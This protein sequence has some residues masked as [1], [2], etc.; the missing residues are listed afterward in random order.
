MSEPSTR[1]VAETGS[2]S[3]EG[4]PACSWTKAKQDRCGYS[5]HVKLF[6]GASNRGAWAIGSAV[7][8]KERPDL[9]P[10]NEVKNMNL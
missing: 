2:R 4:C 8:L 10:R 6:Y 5:S 1:G 3:E 7:I 9:Q